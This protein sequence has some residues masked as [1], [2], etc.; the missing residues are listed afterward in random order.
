MS[1]SR[2]HESEGQV[3]VWTGNAGS[4]FSLDV[5]IDSKFGP[6]LYDSTGRAVTP[7]SPRLNYH[8]RNAGA[9]CFDIVLD[10]LDDIWIDRLTSAGYRNVKPHG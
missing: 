4:S 1:T 8:G 6:R 2:V 10:N 3:Q 5:V 7:R 9:T